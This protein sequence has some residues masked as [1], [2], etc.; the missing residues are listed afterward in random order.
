M[1]KGYIFKFG[2]IWTK[3][4]IFHLIIRVTIISLKFIILLK[5]TFDI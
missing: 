2:V 3:D 5:S 4:E 1:K